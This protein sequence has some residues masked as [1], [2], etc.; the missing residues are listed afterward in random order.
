[1]CASVLPVE[2]WRETNANESLIR[3]H[4][5]EEAV[6]FSRDN[7]ESTYFPVYNSDHEIVGALEFLIMNDE[8]NDI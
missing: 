2:G 3:A 5:G 4:S 7:S 6:H 1:M 8:A